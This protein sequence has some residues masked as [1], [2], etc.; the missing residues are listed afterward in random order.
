V[1]AWLSLF[2]SQR[3]SSGSLKFSISCTKQLGWLTTHK[4]DQHL[5]LGSYPRSPKK[6]QETSKWEVLQPIWMGIR[7]RKPRKQRDLDQWFFLA[8]SC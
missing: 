5:S 8:G 4:K 3:H 7:G 6:K 2:L 1:A